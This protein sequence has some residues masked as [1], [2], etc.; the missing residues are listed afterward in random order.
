M[1]KSCKNN[2]NDEDLPIHRSRQRAVKSWDEQ[3]KSAEYI[4]ARL[5]S[6]PKEDHYEAVL[7]QHGVRQ[8]KDFALCKAMVYQPIIGNTTTFRKARNLKKRQNCKDGMNIEELSST[9]F[10]KVLSA[11]RIKT[12]KLDNAKSCASISYN[13]AQQ[14][15]NLL[16]Q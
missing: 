8:P 11:K 12:F 6:I 15:A 10:A 16:N 2:F 13:V 1:S 5:D 9:D 4:Q 7:Y 3:G 14:V